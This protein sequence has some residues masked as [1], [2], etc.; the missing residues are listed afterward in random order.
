MKNWYKNIRFIVILSLFVFSAGKASAQTV[1]VWTGTGSGPGVA[2]NWT[3]PANW[4][5]GGVTATTYPG[6]T[7]NTDSVQFAMSTYFG[8]SARPILK[9]TDSISVASI[10][11]GDNSS[12]NNTEVDVYIDIEG[13]L[14]VTGS[15]LQLHS[16]NVGLA[17][18]GSINYPLGYNYHLQTW[19]YGAGKVYCSTFQVGDNTIPPTIGINNI[20][21]FNL[22]NTNNNG[23][24]LTVKVSGNFIVNSQTQNDPS[25]GQIL[26][27][28]NA[29]V[30]MNAGSLTIGGQLRLQNSGE[31]Y[32]TTSQFQPQARFSLTA[33]ANN[34][35]TTLYLQGANALY[36]QPIDPI[37]HQY[38]SNFFDF[39]LIGNNQVNGTGTN[40]GVDEPLGTTTVVYSGNVDQEVYTSASFPVSTTLDNNGGNYQYL[41]F[42]GSGKK[43]FDA[44]TDPT[45]FPVIISGDITLASG[46]ETVDLST[47]N[48]TFKLNTG[49]NITYNTYGGNSYVSTYVIPIVSAFTS[50]TGTT[51]QN[52]T[53]ALTF[54]GN[55]NNGGIF[56]TSASTVIMNG[57]FSNSGTFNQ[58]GAATITASNTT[59]NSGIYNQ[60]GSGLLTLTGAFTNSGTFNQTSSGG[61]TASNATIN[62]GTYNQSGTGALT[63]N[64][65]VDNQGTINYTNTG[66]INFNNTFTNSLATSLFSQSNGTINFNNSYSNTGTFKASAGTVNLNQSGAQ[67]LTDNSA[68]NAGTTF[69]NLNVQNGGT[70]T[71]S[72]SGK[73]QFYVASQG[74]LNL[75]AAT[76]LASNGFLTLISDVNGAATV[77]AIPTGCSVTGN[78]TVQRY[79][80]ANR[81]Y[82][83]MSSPVYVGNDGTNNYLGV[84]YLLTNTVVTGSGS[85][86]NKPG[87]PT[88][89]LWRENL[90]PQYTTFLNSNYVGISDISNPAAYGLSDAT[91]PTKDIPVGNGFLF[92]YRGSIKQATIGALTTAGAAATTDTLNAVGTLN[93][94]SVTVHP[95]YQGSTAN[96]GWSTVN[97]GNPLIQGF[98]LVGNPY[99]SSIDWDKLDTVNSTG[100]IYAPHVTAF[101]YQLVPVGL[102]GGGNYNVYMAGSSS[103]VGSLNVANS[104]IIASG[105]GFFVQA[106]SGAASLTFSEAA[107]TNTEK[108]GANLLMGKPVAN[109]TPQYLRI[110]LGMDTLNTDGT[111]IRFNQNAKSNFDVAEDARYRIGTGKVSLS[112]LSSDN[113]AVAYNQLPLALKGDTIHLNVK[114][115]TSGTFSF[116]IKELVGIPQLY[117]VLLVDAKTNDTTDLR[118]T[119]SYSFTINTS[120]TTTFGAHRFSVVINQNP[121]LQYKLI[122]F[123]GSQV[124]TSKHVQLTWSTV[125][126]QNYTHFT[127]ERS[128]DNGKTFS[129]AGGLVSTGAGTYALLDNYAYDGDNQ[130]RLKQEDFNNTITYSNI[131]DVKIS[132]QGSS[133]HVTIY[134]NPASSNISISFV[135]KAVSK[136]T[137]NLRISNSAGI[138]V[139][140]AALS[141]PSWQGNISNLLTG[142]YLVQI[143]DSKDNTIIGQ[144]K[145][146]KL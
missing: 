87:N 2:N 16:N 136:T 146:V 99:A 22:G 109:V 108:T 86:F 71:L 41:K 103:K 32:W 5:V 100:A 65:T 68:A 29:N 67:S 131:V 6:Q 9:S 59:N 14:N 23:I 10:K 92:Y 127:V 130:Y 111:V 73:G 45:N 137:Y 121:A 95:W 8:Y 116:N 97:A 105:Q 36:A 81:G 125:N 119:Q 139:K 82:R 4:T 93:Q 70:K 96:L 69:F 11:I 35:N 1:Y 61:V 37:S 114:A 118:K 15:I 140:Y 21:R 132:S 141:E 106:T 77:S 66:V 57:P 49:S 7:G 128:N 145:F 89:Y 90:V 102:P 47:N 25:T 46:T 40:P 18:D 39:Y 24:G 85:G 42:S 104:N 78:V 43:T 72:G 88:L 62:S 60:G 34:T 55:V 51:F 33:R 64:G 112:S 79:M 94:G 91:Y 52:G 122:S 38:G 63:F 56:N 74:L 115:T 3:S 117:N 107:K 19:F 27:V 80:S 84:N 17:G 129:V 133:D 30:S 98:N 50:T 138:V 76:T 31:I 113:V 101:C 126:E 144:T 26:A 124:G 123:N 20:T 135:P 142:S 83:L 58:S 48:P 143:V 53:K 28:S 13:K 110:Q 120:D 75:S 54:P 134:P 12:T 44:T